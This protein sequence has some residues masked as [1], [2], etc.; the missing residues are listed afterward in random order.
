MSTKTMW[1]IYI[2]IHANSLATHVGIDPES[3]CQDSFRSSLSRLKALWHI[4]CSGWELPRQ[5]SDHWT[6]SCLTGKKKTVHRWISVPDVW[7]PVWKCSCWWETDVWRNIWPVQAHHV[8]TLHRVRLTW[9]IGRSCPLKLM[10]VHLN[11]CQSQRERYCCH[12]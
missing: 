8:D 9:Q 1:F 12:F 11:G 10:F 6:L 5:P 4:C 3:Q 7:A 2:P